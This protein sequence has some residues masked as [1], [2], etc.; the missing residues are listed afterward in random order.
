MSKIIGIDLGTT[1]SAMAAM[2]SGK[3]EIITNSEG[4][5]TTPSVVA[6]NK[7]GERLVGQ[8]ARRQQVTNPK[9]TIYEVKRLIG[10]NFD[11]KEVQRDIK[12]MGY[13]IVKSGNGVKVKMDGKDYS[14]EEVSAMILSKLKADAESF[15]GDKVTEAVITVPAYFDD[16]QRQATKDAGKI[17]GLEVKRIIN[18]PTA[19]ALAYGLDKGDKKD[20]KIA[21]YDLGGGTFD[22]SI[23]ELGDGVFEVKSTNGDTHLGGADFDRVLVNYF[24]D[25]FKKEHGID[26]TGDNAAMQRLRDEAEKAKIELS[27]AQEVDIN[28][29]FLT[30]DAGGPKHFEHK[31]TRAK[32][33]SLVADLVDKTA[34]PCE[35]A[36]KDADLKASDIDAV[37]LVGGMTRMPAVQEKVKQIFSKDPMK[38][39]NPD[40]V[41]AIGAAIQGGVLQGDVKDVLL[42]DVTPL[43][44]GIETMGGVMTKLIERN[45]TIPTSKSEVFSTAAD[46]QPQVE[47]H[48][49]QGERE[50]VE[51][52][53]SLGRFILD[54]IPPAPR[55]I[56][57][58][59]VIFNI[60][61]NGILHV[62]AKDKGTGKEQSITISGSG[63]LDKTEVERMAKEAESHAEEDKTK[64]DLVEAHNL[65]DG[66]V[67]QAEKL[68]K[69]YANK[70]S[71]DDEKTL[72]EAVESAKKVV[73][74]EKATKD[75]LEK[76]AKELNDKLMPIG[77]KMYE[78]SSS[79]KETEATTDESSKDDKED[80]KEADTKDKDGTIEGEVVDD[81]KD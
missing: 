48:V 63:N 61:A 59:E 78:Q 12:L 6:V 44:L 53:K 23:L 14:P 33:E 35:K 58:V 30:A 4:N 1:N 72:D 79:E 16:S 17:A 49:A 70:I 28:L 76:A 73:A 67:Y 71:E 52:N 3:P 37:V 74:D 56:P 64:K 40:E 77:A 5:R 27:T 41:V 21:V 38:G 57:Q 10:R 45:T 18:E 32:L 29:P 34:D 81:K 80:D 24:A 47:I 69:D 42:L 2:Q 68:K 31:L 11:D 50:I 19:A 54:G 66:A 46:N 36:L 39:V 65:L 51:G 75:D 26:I 13:E 7:N 9:N 62:T 25:E 8:V 20:E 43:S 15:L 22:V 55:G 60:D